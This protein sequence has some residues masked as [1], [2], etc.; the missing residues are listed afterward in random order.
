VHAD[1]VHVILH[2]GFNGINQRDEVIINDPKQYL[3]RTL[4]V[5]DRVFKFRDPQDQVEVLIKG[6][7]L[8]LVCGS[9]EL[10]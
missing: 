7:V 10:F 8:D 5:L 1:R 6:E 4:L 9:P 3:L 2:S